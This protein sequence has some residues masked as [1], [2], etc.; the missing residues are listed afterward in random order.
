MP[1]V[2][3]APPG[4]SMVHSVALLLLITGV[5]LALAALP[6]FR[7]AASDHIDTLKAVVHGERPVPVSA[8]V[9]DTKPAE[10]TKPTTRREI[11]DF[12]FSLFD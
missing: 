2:P 6:S 1:P 9:D 10:P 5:A 11:D 3:A 8:G 12:D 4:A 7:R